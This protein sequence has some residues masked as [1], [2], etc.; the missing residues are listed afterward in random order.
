MA[1]ASPK[2][3]ATGRTTESS[4]VI[5]VKRVYEP[6]ARSDGCRVLVDR[7][8]PR[9]LRKDDVAL[10]AWIKDVAPST[11]LRKWF[12]HDPARWEEFQKRYRDELDANPEAVQAVL[13][14][15]SKK[16]LTLLFGAKDEERNQAVVLAEYL[17]R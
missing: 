16:T 3:R 11:E 12:G 10:D 8:W 5:R 1:K 14:A 6:P 17:T 15:C 7:I 4:P 2:G 9:G 13:D